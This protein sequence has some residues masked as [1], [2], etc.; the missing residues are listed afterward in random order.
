LNDNLRPKGFQVPLLPPK[1]LIG[2]SCEPDFLQKRKEDL[3]KW[4]DQ[5]VR[6]K[7]SAT[8]YSPPPLPCCFWPIILRCFFFCFVVFQKSSP[9]PPPPSL[10]P[11]PPL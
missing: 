2:S 4:L 3:S 10:S 1:K 7:K 5:L 11:P 9:P 6:Q 8:V